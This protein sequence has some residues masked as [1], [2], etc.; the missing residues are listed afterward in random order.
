M[1]FLGI[2]NTNNI[3][4]PKLG[5]YAVGMVFLPND[6]TRASIAQKAIEKAISDEGQ[7]LIGWRKVPTDDSVLGKSVVGNKPLIKQFFIQKSENCKDEI[8]FQKENFMLSEKFVHK[9]CM[10]VIYWSGRTST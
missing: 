1:N 4:L 3:L 10:K 7:I 5:S 6:E 2:F 8:Q 9:N